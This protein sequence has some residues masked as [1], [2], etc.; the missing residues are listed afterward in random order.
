MHASRSSRFVVRTLAREGFVIFHGT[1]KRKLPDVLKPTV[2]KPGHRYFPPKERDPEYVPGRGHFHSEALRM[3]R[4]MTPA[5]IRRLGEFAG[6]DA[7]TGELIPLEQVDVDHRVM[8]IACLALI[9]RTMGKP[10]EMSEKP[11]QEVLADMT[12]EE[13]AAHTANLL[14]EGGMARSTAMKFLRTSLKLDKER[15]EE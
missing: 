3:A 14:I 15:G 9:E 6:I 4:M 2:F 8:Q 11:P 12:D 10:R 7:D 13:L 1:A 5:A